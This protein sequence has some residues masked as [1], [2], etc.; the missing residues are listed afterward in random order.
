GSVHIS[1]PSHVDLP[2]IPML[3]MPPI[4]VAVVARRHGIVTTA[5]LVRA[6]WSPRTIRRVAA[7]GG[8][9]RCHPGVYRVATAPDTFASRCAAAWAAEPAPLIT[10]LAAGRLW[11]FHPI[12]TPATH[13]I[14]V[15]PHGRRALA[16]DDIVVRRSDLLTTEDVVARPDGIRVASPPRAWFD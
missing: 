13:P 15:L 2:R 5:Q 1:A 16:G 8:L 6:G 7:A 10:G 12:G 3:H 14:V 4:V 11:G 9:V